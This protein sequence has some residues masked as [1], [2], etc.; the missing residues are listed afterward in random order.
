MILTILTI[1]TLTL[2][3]PTVF[4]TLVVHM[5]NKLDQQDTQYVTRGSET[6]H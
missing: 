5:Q 4:I 6:L 1:M 3:I 2:I